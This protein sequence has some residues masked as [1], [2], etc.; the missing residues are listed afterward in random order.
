[1]NT[2]KFRLFDGRKFRTDIYIG[3]DG[4]AYKLYN[5]YGCMFSSGLKCDKLEGIIQQ[6]TGLY[7]SNGKEIWEGDLC[8]TE[9]SNT[10]LNGLYQVKWDDNKA[11]YIYDRN[12]FNSYQRKVIHKYVVGYGK[13]YVVGNICTHNQNG[14]ERG[15]AIESLKNILNANSGKGKIALD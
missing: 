12:D 2:I 7:D 4:N 3:P 6:F 11:H 1:M 10:Y 5:D 14:E 8:K 9:R 15:N 13:C